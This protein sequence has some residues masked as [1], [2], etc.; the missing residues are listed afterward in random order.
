MAS[1]L[2]FLES[3]GAQNFRTKTGWIGIKIRQLNV[4]ERRRRSERKER[5]QHLFSN[6]AVQ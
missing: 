2:A 1:V 6:Y 5:T 3:T 4:Y